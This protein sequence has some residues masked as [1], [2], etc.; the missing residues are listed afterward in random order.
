MSYRKKRHPSTAVQPAPHTVF[1][2]E[3]SD[4][5]EESVISTARLTSGLALSA[6]DFRE[7][8]GPADPGMG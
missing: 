5:G 7:D 1:G 3:Y 8:G 4:L 6:A 2:R